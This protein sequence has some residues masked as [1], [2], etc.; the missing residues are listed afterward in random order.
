MKVLLIVD[1]Q[2]DFCPG[3]SLAVPEG[4]RIMSV[5]NQALHDPQFDLRVASRDWHPAEHVSFVDNYPGGRLYDQVQVGAAKQILWPR[6]CESGTP[7]A[8]LHPSITFSRID[9]LI[10]K[11]TDA[12]VDSYSAFFDN[13]R[14]RETTLRALLETEAARRGESLREVSLTVCG[15]ALDYCVAATL[16]DARSLGITCE[17]ILDATRAVN[18]TPGDDVRVLRELSELGVAITESRELFASHE[19]IRGRAIER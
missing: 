2:V 13:N 14:S 19:R 8:Q 18:I 1:P 3:G 11:G 9:H 6:H 16:R 7:G 17:L 10:D 12:A 4:D 15:L 5:V